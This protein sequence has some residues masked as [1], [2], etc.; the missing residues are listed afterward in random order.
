M[1]ILTGNTADLVPGLLNGSIDLGLLT[2]PV[3]NRQLRSRFFF[4]DTLVCIAP[5]A[6]ASA[7]RR[8]QARNLEGRQLVLYESGGSIRRSIDRWLARADRR[9]M[10]VTDI[11]SADA[12]LAFVRAGFGW[13]IISEI[14]ARE[15]AA[16][17]RIELRPLDPPLYRDL[18]LVWR[19]DRAARPIIAAAMEAFFGREKP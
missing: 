6:E 3:H 15:D 10:R 11:G 13:S 17:G 16:A 12:Q 9:R 7:S 4:R 19:R 2:A 14:A 8:V 18:V 5:P 1:R